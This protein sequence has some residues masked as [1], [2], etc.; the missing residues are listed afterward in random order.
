GVAAAAGGLA[1]TALAKGFSR[2]NAI[3]QAEAKLRGLG[4]TTGEITQI[5]QNATAAV[6]GTAFGLDEAATAAASAL[7]SG[8]EPGRQLEKYLTLI[9]DAATQGGAS[10]TEMASIINKTTATGK[11]GMEN[12][13]QL[14][15]RGIGIMSWLADEYGV[16]GAELAKMVSRGEVDTKTFRK[17]L[18]DNIGG[19]AQ[20]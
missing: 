18:E 6:T 1:A 3:D 7:A 16:T 14:S 13:N 15:E 12:L 9:G 10:F 8:V 4:H 19:A 2:L 20:E 11:V 17:V 5:M